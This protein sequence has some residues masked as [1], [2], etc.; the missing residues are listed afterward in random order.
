MKKYFIGLF[1]LISIGIAL[2][3]I[4]IKQN[5]LLD[6]EVYLE[7]TESVRNLKLLDNQIN[8][9]LFGIRYANYSDYNTIEDRTIALSDEFDN[10]RYEALFEE[11]ES[12][13]A[14]GNATIGFEKELVKKQDHIDN[15]IENHQRLV[16]ANND[17]LQASEVN[18]PI[19]QI[20]EKLS[21]RPEII[22]ININFYR[23]LEQSDIDNRNLL[24]DDIGRIQGMIENYS[25]EEQD[26]V[27]AY[28]K[29]LSDIIL[30]TEETQK[31]FLR[32][33][34]QET[35]DRLNALE[36][37]Y[38]NYH[39]ILI[40]KAN[41]IRNA[42]IIY[43]LVLLVLLTIFAY[44]LRRQY[45]N[46][47]QQVAD[48]TEEIQQTYND[49]QESQEQLIQSEK[50]AS[51]GEMVAGVAHEINTPLGYVNSNIT[52]SAANLGDM[53]AVFEQFDAVYQEACKKPR[54]NKALST[55]LSS[56]LRS[57]KAVDS[58][59]VVEE[60]QQLLEDSHHGIGE[61]SQLVMSLKDFSRLDRQ[62]T[63]EVDIHD[64]I[65][66]AVKIASNPI[67]ENNVTIVKNLSDLPSLVCT[68]SK[69]NQLFLNI[70]TNAAQAMKENGGELRI[71]TQQQ[72]DN[73]VIAFA[74]Q[75]VGMDQATQQ[76]MFDPFFT[77][78]PI[79]EG[80]GLGMSIAY[81]IVQAHKGKINVSSILGSGTTIEI[82]LPLNP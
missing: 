63:A 46:L 64:C 65:E 79:G 48:R 54:N 6:D 78:K 23:Y 68:P 12:S 26:V 75:G 37:A 19:N 47:E 66:N 25:D 52:T 42:L 49:L 71:S 33:T 74:D 2:A 40:E 29:T 1:I 4:T 24:N 81:K 69:L 21:L 32:A 53:T 15:F 67:R 3:Y 27:F 57:Y 61:I 7:T 30:T 50:M 13:E 38:V 62:S 59:G 28:I 41:K 31:Y 5:M 20:V 10:L 17:F 51:L 9:L 82:V 43:G 36:S 8:L 35:G 45:A 58:D 80:T 44:L 14:L 70:I 73:L 39:N 11:I 72:D 56:A 18:S 76:K 16:E 22:S 77:S 34:Q 60:T 55:A